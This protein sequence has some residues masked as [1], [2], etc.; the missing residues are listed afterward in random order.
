MEI[1]CVEGITSQGSKNEN[2]DS[3]FC[4]SRL[5]IVIDGAS[6][7]IT[8]KNVPS[9]RWL[10]N[11]F[12]RYLI[13]L[14]ESDLCLKEI[15]KKSINRILNDYKEEY[16]G[17]DVDRAYWPSAAASI[18]LLR[19]DTLE[20]M[21]FGDSPTIL[22]TKE[23]DFRVF[24]D[25]RIVKLDNIVTQFI[26]KKVLSGLRFSQAYREALPLLIKHRRTLCTDR[27]YSALSLNESCIDQALYGDIRA[28]NVEYLL[29][30]TD[31]FTRIIDVFNYVKNYRE[32]LSTVL[33]K[34]LAYLMV[35]LRELESEDTNCKN[36]PRLSI[37][38]DA[39]ALLLK[40]R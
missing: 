32:L 28:K 12:M 6:S 5:A 36:Y 25:E 19:G 39:T 14:H 30:A 40:I 34:G 1:V 10:V 22:Y 9:A 16:G 27:G 29:L 23:G 21:V 13:E 38:D 15:V 3:M 8:S 7:L 33:T 18:I 24:R 4:N 35:K 31:G 26:H 17:L 11:K 37:S 20:Y 2:E